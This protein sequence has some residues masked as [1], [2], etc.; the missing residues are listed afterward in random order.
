MFTQNRHIKARRVPARLLIGGLAAAG[1]WIVLLSAIAFAATAAIDDFESG[2]FTGGTGWLADW[3][4]SGS[5]DI[6]QNGDSQSG[7]WHMRL[8][9]GD[10]IAYRD[11]DLTGWNDTELTVWV[12]AK[13]F[14]DDEYARLMLGPPGSLVEAMRWD[15]DEYHLYT[16]ELSAFNPGGVFR[17]QFESHMGDNSDE[18]FVDSLVISGDQ[19]AS[20]PVLPV[21]PILECVLDNGDG[22]YTAFFGYDNQNETTSTLSV[23]ADNGFNPAPQG[24]GQPTTFEPGRTALYPNAAFS[25]AFDGSNL[26]WTLNGSVASA[27]SASTQCSQPPPPSL[28]LIVLDGEFDD[29]AGRANIVDP[30]GDASKQRGDILR[31]Y[32]GDNESETIF[33]MVERPTGETK[34][35]SYAVHLDMNNDG[36]F[37]DDVDR[38]IEVE[39]HPRDNDSK[40]D[41][42]VRRADN[43]KKL[44]EYKKQ[45]WGE[46]KQ[47]GGSR[48]E[49]GVP[50]EDLQFS[51]GAAFRMYVESN[52]NDRAPDTGDIQWSP[53]PILGFIGMALALGLGGV[54]IWWFRLRKYEGGEVP[55][56]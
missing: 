56:T 28:S 20:P 37:T 27:S 52:F 6:V 8:R 7:S 14:E 38:I 15:G 39:Y 41:V 10:G 22:T 46:S 53:M 17:V 49:F 26:T 51:F 9:A 43:N 11:V 45:D 36:D 33:W 40:V 24:R 50:T 31:F 5:V 25:V 13:S 42:K 32:W 3:Q 30:A 16:I 35:V 2:G 21:T 44:T 48:V 29:W 34:K 1:L 55:R 47:E 4:T 12:R 54:A 19:P 18:L 23:D